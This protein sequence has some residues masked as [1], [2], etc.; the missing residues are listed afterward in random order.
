[1]VK[2]HKI[3]VSWWQRRQRLAARLSS[4]SG[5]ARLAGCGCMPLCPDIR[6]PCHPARDIHVSPAAVVGDV[7]VGE[8]ARVVG[9][10]LVVGVDLVAGVVLAAIGGQQ[11]LSVQHSLSLAHGAEGKSS[12]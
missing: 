2:R 1:M 12:L 8:G 11:I 9:D 4:V 3:F 7:P 10:A 6:P 5:A